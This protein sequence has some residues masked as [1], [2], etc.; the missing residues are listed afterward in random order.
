MSRRMP[1]LQ[2]R[3]INAVYLQQGFCV[4]ESHHSAHFSMEWTKGQ[5]IL[6]IYILNGAGHLQT[7]KC[8]YPMRKGNVLILPSKTYYRISD[9]PKDPLSIYLLGIHN[10]EIEKWSSLSG[11][12]AC[13]VTTNHIVCSLVQH[14]FKKLL[15]ENTIKRPAWELMMVSLVWEMLG[16]LHRGQSE[17]TNPSKGTYDQQS[18]SRA[19]VARYVRDISEN[20]YH[21][22]S[23]EQA[24]ASTSLCVRRFGILFREITG[25]S[26]RIFLQ[27]K[28]VQHAKKLLSETEHSI[29]SICFE[30]G[31]NELSTFYRC[32]N[33]HEKISPKKWREATEKSTIVP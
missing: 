2:H 16:I 13:H 3:P 15:Y 24:A 26:W 17:E 18:M 22:Q 29:I 12:N 33:K 5:D 23:L 27:D 32:F 7:K 31:F 6:I 8:K 21:H 30:C 20:F 19:R 10:P 1:P 11:I 9:N 4:L 14:R 25:M 28:R